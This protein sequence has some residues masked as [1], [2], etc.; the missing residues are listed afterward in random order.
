MVSDQNI[1]LGI[2]RPTSG[3][4]WYLLQQVFVGGGYFSSYFNSS[5]GS[6]NFIGAI[7]EEFVEVPKVQILQPAGVLRNIE[8]ILHKH[9][10]NHSDYSPSSSQDLWVLF[11]Q[12][13]EGGV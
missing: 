11:Y 10:D 9:Y 5:A 2:Q 6:I 1:Q 8:F 13:A 7:S 3:F 4:M 12:Y